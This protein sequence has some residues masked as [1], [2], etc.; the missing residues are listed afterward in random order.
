MKKYFFGWTNIKWFI[1]ETFNIFS[2]KPSYFSKKRMES[3]VA[4]IIAQFGMVYFLVKNVDKMN[5]YDICIWA[6]TEFAVAGYMI[7]HIQKEKKIEIPQNEEVPSEEDQ[8]NS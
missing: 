5:T 7:S 4:F 2:S 8:L 3:G 6:A 1:K